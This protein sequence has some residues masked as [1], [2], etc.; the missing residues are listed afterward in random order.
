MKK[1]QVAVPVADLRHSPDH[2]SERVSQALYGQIV[3]IHDEHNDFLLCEGDDGYGGWIGRSYLG[4]V[5][6]ATTSRAIVTSP[7]A[8]FDANNRGGRLQLPYGAIIASGGRDTFF[9]RDGTALTLINGRL[10]VTMPI[11][12]ASALDEGVGLISTPYLWGGTSGFG[13][14]C[15]GLTQAVFRRLGVVLPRDSK[16]QALA[17]REV[18]LDAST[19]G[20]LIFFPGHVAIHLGQRSILHSSRLRGVV[21]I[22]SLDPQL[23][24]YRRDLAEKFTAVRRVLE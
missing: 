10:N 21:A 5:M 18:A 12:L 9:G 3:N 2:R 4:E 24:H 6:A 22:E 11:S 23:P 1:M 20:D 7:F 17:G 8:L 14:D 15:S 19:A 16:D 13:F